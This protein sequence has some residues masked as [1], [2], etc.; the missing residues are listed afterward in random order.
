MLAIEEDCRSALIRQWEL[1]AGAVPAIEL[2]LPSRISGWTNKEVLAHLYV[3]PRLL[4]RFLRDSRSDEPVMGTA[5][6]LAGTTTLRDL[7]DSSAREGAKLNRFDLGITL[8][9]ARD[10]VLRA[11]LHSTI[12]S[13]Q[14]P[15]SAYD[16]L[17]TRCVEAVVHGCDLVDPIHP[18]RVAQTITSS[19]LLD[20]LAVS[21]PQLVAEASA[22]PIDEWID[23]AT[24]R[25]DASG[26]LAAVLPVMA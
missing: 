16:Y 23:L 21:S 18:D 17:V 8:T 7:I 25:K 20:V 26:P 3:Q 22:L 15:I 14:G 19:A 1:I 2:S 6:N 5:E 11:D 24:G 13:L 9:E 4:A 10:L 12:V